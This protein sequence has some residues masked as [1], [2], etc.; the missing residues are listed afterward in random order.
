MAELHCHIEGAA[1]PG[2]VCMLARRYGIDLGDIVRDDFYVWHDFSSFLAAYDRASTV[3]RSE[4]DFAELATDHLTRLA[5]AGTLYAEFFISPDHAKLSGVAPEAYAAGLATGIA[6]AREATGIEARMI[7]VGVRHLGV[8]AVERAARFA[9]GPGRRDITGFGLAGDERIGAHADFRKAFDIA[10]D[11]G[12]GLTIHAGEVCG[13]E[14]VRAAIDA[15]APH[16]IGHGVRAIEDAALIA[17]IARRGIVLEVCPG[18]NLALGLYPDIASH[19]LKRLV[20]AGVKVTLGADDPPFFRTSLAAEYRLAAEAGIDAPGRL[21]F[22]RTA[23]EAAF[24]DETT[25]R[26]LI[27]RLM[28]AALSLGAPGTSQ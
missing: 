24:V 3:F 5:S 20:A 21:A 1:D 28:L 4:E 11:A 13:A 9:A 26:R 8:E 2:L 7:V 18:S 27:D 23:I 14:S 16:R 19:P 12:L 25:R 6:R 22:T 17:E 10:R 15:V